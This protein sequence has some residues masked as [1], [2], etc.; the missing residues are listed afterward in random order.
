[1][2]MTFPRGR[3][4]KTRVTLFTLIIF[5]CSIW[6]L[7]LFVSFRLRGDMLRLLNK[8]QFATVSFMAAEADRELERLLA[9]LGR[10]ASQMNIEV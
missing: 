2:A 6:S 10:T 8:Q 9:A 3:S 1:M 5:L 4:L 7:E